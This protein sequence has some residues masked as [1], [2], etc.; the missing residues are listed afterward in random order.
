MLTNFC[1]N[2]QTLTLSIE[3]SYIHTCNN[4]KSRMNGEKRLCEQYKP[5]HF[6]IQ[7]EKQRMARKINKACRDLRLT[8]KEIRKL[9]NCC[10]AVYTQRNNL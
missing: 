10:T 3:K 6:S 1:E 5:M 7:R 4:L 2:L 9:Q 8:K